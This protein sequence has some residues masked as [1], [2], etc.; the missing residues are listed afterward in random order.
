MDLQVKVVVSRVEHPWYDYGTALKGVTLKGVTL[1]GVTLKG[2]IIQLHL[3][4][5]FLGTK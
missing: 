2:V 3:G 4:T 1:K 5:P